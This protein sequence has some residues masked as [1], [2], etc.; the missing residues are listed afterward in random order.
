MDTPAENGKQHGVVTPFQIAD[1][2]RPLL[3][4]GKICERGDMA[5][6]FTKDGAAVV[7]AREGKEVTVVAK[8]HKRNG[9]YVATMDVHNPSHPGFTRQAR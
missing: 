2:T 3:S 9:L 8:F 1:I 4:V 7:D 6:M 5:V